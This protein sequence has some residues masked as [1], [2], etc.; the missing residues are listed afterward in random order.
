MLILFLTRSW[1]LHRPDGPQLQRFRERPC[2]LPGEDGTRDILS[3]K[4]SILAMGSKYWPSEKKGKAARILLGPSRT[5]GITGVSMQF[6]TWSSYFDP[7]DINSLDPAISTSCSEPPFVETVR[8]S[9]GHCRRLNGLE[10]DV[11][12]SPSCIDLKWK[13]TCRRRNMG[14]FKILVTWDIP[15]LG[16]RQ[17][18]LFG[19]IIIHAGNLILC[20]SVVYKVFSNV[21]LPW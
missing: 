3:S 10:R 21:F 16:P 7:I 13:E 19:I 9:L 8:G 1:R 17:Y 18:G 5:L 4:I 11:G 2:F 20:L 6:P 15:R 12:P 14:S